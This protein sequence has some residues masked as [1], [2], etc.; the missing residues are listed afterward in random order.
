MCRLY[1]LL[2]VVVL[3][4]FSQITHAIPFTFEGRSL[5]MGGVG[6]ATANLATAAW[7]NPAM[8]TNQPKNSDWSL[9]IGLGAFVREMTMIWQGMW[10]T[11]RMQMSAGKRLVAEPKKKLA[12]YWKWRRLLAA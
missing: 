1:K 10:T 11:T 2:A 6:V 7:A 4:A 3:S 8:L 9:L 12:R 5:G